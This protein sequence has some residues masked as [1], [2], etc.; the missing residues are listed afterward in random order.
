M[1]LPSNPH[2][3]V[4]HTSCTGPEL[5]SVSRARLLHDGGEFGARRAENSMIIGLPLTL[6]L[7][8][9]NDNNDNNNNV[10]YKHMMIMIIC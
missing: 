4:S 3:S 8:T 1:E 10:R 9:G 2:I 7:I 5:A 6:L